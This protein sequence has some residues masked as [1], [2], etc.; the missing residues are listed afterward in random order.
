M[1]VITYRTTAPL[2][3]HDGFV[4]LT[5]EQAVPRAGAL[6]HAGKGVYQ[7]KAP[8]QFKAGEVVGF[9]DTP[10]KAVLQSLELLAGPIAPLKP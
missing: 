1:T 5:K 9:Q 10:S 6:Q 8:L 4:A 3:L 2:M 7:V